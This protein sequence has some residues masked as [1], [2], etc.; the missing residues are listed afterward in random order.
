MLAENGEIQ[1]RI[2]HIAVRQ[3]D[4]VLACN[5]WDGIFRRRGCQQVFILPVERVEHIVKGKY[6]LLSEFVV[7][8]EG[9]RPVVI[10][11]L[12]ILI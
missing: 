11:R 10:I 2:R 12:G 7:G 9:D 5:L 3:P 1:F 6:M 4:D 8:S